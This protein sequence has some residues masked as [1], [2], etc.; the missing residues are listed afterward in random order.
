[1]MRKLKENLR[2]L[3]KITIYIRF[4]IKYDSKLMENWR[5]LNFRLEIQREQMVLT[6][7]KI[8]DKSCLIDLED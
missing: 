5:S 4:K 2:K 7:K 3:R 8:K 6:E 1:M